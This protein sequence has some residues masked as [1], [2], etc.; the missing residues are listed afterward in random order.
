MLFTVSKY[1]YQ[2]DHLTFLIHALNC[3]VTRNI[4]ISFLSLCLLSSQ[5]EEVNPLG[6]QSW[7]F[8]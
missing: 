2:L 5:N 1:V 8:R 3:N 6:S 4:W 7:L